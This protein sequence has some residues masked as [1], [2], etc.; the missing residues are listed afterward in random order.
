MDS[1]LAKLLVVSSICIISS[2]S[3]AICPDLTVEEMNT[4]KCINHDGEESEELHYGGLYSPYSCY[5]YG[6][7]LNQSTKKNL[8]L[9]AL[10]EARG[11]NIEIKKHEQ[12]F[13][14][15]KSECVYER[16]FDGVMM[17]SYV[18]PAPQN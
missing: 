7:R 14:A 12:K 4:I 6:S 2:N 16:N 8:S 10:I 11:G 9:K 17:V 13:L 5:F 15:H 3:F 18:K 1:K